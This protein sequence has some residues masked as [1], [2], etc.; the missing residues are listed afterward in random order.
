MQAILE[1]YQART[2]R[3]RHQLTGAVQPVDTLTLR[4]DHLAE[5]ME[6]AMRIFLSARQSCLD[7]QE[8][9][10]RQ[11]NP[12]QILALH[13][14]KVGEMQRRLNRIGTGLI[15]E[16]EQA[17]A[18]SAG[19]LEAVSPLSTLARGY[20]VARKTS[21]K[22]AVITNAEQVQPGEQ[23]EVLLHQGRLECTV[24]NRKENSIGAIGCD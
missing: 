15:H 7:R 12:L 13:E 21:G 19:V 17:L 16:R 18:R 10:F 22:R 24:I 9:C 5:N 23:I 11:N 1:G 14:Q 4:L 8:H 20:A 6:H 2:D 3:Y